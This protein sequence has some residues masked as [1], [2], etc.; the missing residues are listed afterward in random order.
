M[1]EIILLCIFGFFIVLIGWVSKK[2]K[3][4]RKK[5]M[6]L[7]KYL[8]KIEKL[9]NNVTNS[10]ELK[11]YDLT[12]I[13]D[14]EEK[15]CGKLLKFGLENEKVLNIAVTGP[16]GSGK[17]SFLK[18]FESKNGDYN[19]LNISLASFDDSIGEDKDSRNKIEK[20]IEEN[21]LQQIIYKE[22]ADKLPNS[23]I[24][25]IKEISI[26]KF[27][28]N[29]LLFFLWINSF[30]LKF[31][32]PVWWNK[33]INLDDFDKFDKLQSLILILGA[34]YLVYSLAKNFGINKIVIKALDNE[35]ELGNNKETSVFYKYLDEIIY[36][37][38]RT[39][40][41]VVFFED[42]DRFENI[43]V[44]LFTKLRE[45]NGLLNSSDDI[46]RKIKF[47]YAVKDD[48]FESGEE[49][50]TEDSHKLRTKFFDLIV[51]IIPVI[52]Y[53]NS[54]EKLRE[55]LWDNYLKEKYEV[56]TLAIKLE[57]NSEGEE[58]EVENLPKKMLDTLKEGNKIQEW[59]KRFAFYID[60][61][62]VI[63]NIVNEFII[64]RNNIN[65]PDKK[66]EKLSDWKLLGY[67]VY[68][69]L[70]PED[71]SKLHKREGR[72]YEVING[73]IK[74]IEEITT[75][76]QL[77]LEALKKEKLKISEEPFDDI[78]SLRLKFLK[79]I[80]KGKEP[81]IL[82][83]V[84]I[85]KFIKSEE[86]FLK[87]K[88]RASYHDGNWNYTASLGEVEKELGFTYEDRKKLIEEK[89]NKKI[90]VIQNEIDELEKQIREI[91]N[92][93]IKELCKIYGVDRILGNIFENEPFL[94][95]LLK[96]GVVDEKEYHTYISYFYEG[97]L[98]SN[99]RDF[100]LAFRNGKNDLQD[101]SIDN[102]KV[103]ME[104]LLEEEFLDANILNNDLIGFIFKNKENEEIKNK[105]NKFFEGSNKHIKENKY[106][107]I[108][109][110]FLDDR[111]S[112]FIGEFM[113]YI[114]SFY[115]ML[116][117]YDSVE[118]ESY[119]DYFIKDIIEFCDN[120]II[121][122]QNKNNILS[123]YLY[124]NGLIEIF[125]DILDENNDN[126]KYV[127]L[128]EDKF[129]ELL[130]RLCNKKLDKIS[131]TRDSKIFSYFY[132]Y[133]LYEINLENIMN[134]LEIKCNLT[135]QEKV[136]SEIQLYTLIANKK[137]ELKEL[138]EYIDKNMQEFINNVILIEDSKL[139]ESKEFLTK[140]YKLSNEELSLEIKKK[141]IISQNENVEDIKVVD[142]NLWST[143]VKYDKVSPS[144]ENILRYFEYC[145][146]QIDESLIKYL[147]NTNNASV[148]GK[149][150][151]T[152]YDKTLD[153][154]S[155][156]TLDTEIVMCQE[157]KDE[158][159][160]LLINSL[161]SWSIIEKTENISDIRI[162]TM[163]NNNKLNFTR[164]NIEELL[165]NHEEK[166][167]DFLLAHKDIFLGS[168]MH[169]MDYI[170]SNQKE[171]YSQF[172]D[173]INHEEKIQFINNFSLT[174]LDLQDKLW[175]QI[176]DFINTL[177]NFG[178]DK[179]FDEEKA[180][181][182]M[183]WDFLPITVKTVD[184]LHAM[185]TEGDDRVEAI[186][187]S[188]KNELFEKMKELELGGEICFELY[189]VLD[190]DE[191][192]IKFINN[193]SLGSIYDILAEEIIKF[194]LTKKFQVSFE[195]IEKLI[196]M[197][198]EDI[199]TKLFFSQIEFLSH[200]EIKNILIALNE[201]YKKIV[202]NP[203]RSTFDKNDI[204]VEIL[205]KLKEK[206]MLLTVSPKGN[207]ITV[208]KNPDLKW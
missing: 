24:K 97:D 153:E 163:I 53:S 113:E 86:I 168:S 16:Y 200:V 63:N 190:I 147:N 21:I 117:Y 33:L 12:P 37:F 48:L 6:F 47:V 203:M 191:D 152:D 158:S 41:D 144:W 156:K 105:F 108:V 95:F 55:K 167:I 199:K 187:I 116:D 119:Q 123:D 130:P 9:G 82:N 138:K 4:F 121:E 196:N 184:I 15:A 169:D 204:D 58:K 85:L 25:R 148:L 112:Y 137:D 125:E 77:K 189:K 171:I 181:E 133:S 91:K 94:I 51:P 115:D 194:I 135:E 1:L 54:K 45:L 74:K 20:I 172:F 50:R 68:K 110:R 30:Y 66:R 46:K 34:F 180:K 88:E 81:Q 64:Y 71:F 159:F 19:Y 127:K 134:I 40:Y 43:N 28:M 93:S 183:E 176:K 67:I 84:P 124:S 14:S 70:Y 155:S 202:N 104:E 141:L 107:K 195:I 106:I 160:S 157:I 173:R 78:E 39:K 179:E 52:N 3:Y 56:E 69:N 83:D 140:L 80:V 98:S 7:N 26:T 87:L 146:E 182:I 178:L 99:D 17:S 151:L 35:I 142:K 164:E 79:V 102:P 44:D 36:F 42:I 143:L 22:S 90:T 27:T 100:I 89:N 129:I 188:K 60:D 31:E 32:K 23:R 150:K 201:N 131:A 96:E 170:E 166:V 101:I 29:F 38:K 161:Y 10:N 174:E 76:E 118:N 162:T 128:L 103:V 136:L 139:Q 145:D 198:K 192:K 59:I 57:K 62:R 92:Y 75:E 13:D 126:E 205:N 165:K 149:N 208:I 2:P 73:K 114:P 8:K 177:E 122:S 154:E 11:F 111:G 65:N 120:E 186:V 206:G 197:S 5:I 185:I 109:E 61:M 207:K 72:V 193:I 49:E 175:T 132:E 18:S